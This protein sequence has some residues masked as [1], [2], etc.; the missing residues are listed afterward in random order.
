[1]WIFAYGSLIF[2]PSFAHIERRR[3]FLPHFMRRFWQ[4]S[5]DHRGVPEAPGRVATLV[6]APDQWCG[7]CVYRIDAQDATAILAELDIREQAGFER[8]LLSVYDAPAGVAFAEAIVYVARQ[9][10]PHFLG[11]L[12]EPEIAAWVRRSCGPSGPNADYVLALRDALR[13]FDI[14]DTHVEEIAQ[15]LHMKA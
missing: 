12:D 2:R 9:G 6:P 5:P 7:G 8:H 1:M 15:H 11:P 10:N 3:A 13:S 4:G 14:H